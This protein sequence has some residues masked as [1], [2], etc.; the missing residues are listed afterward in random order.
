VSRSSFRVFSLAALILVVGC[1]ADPELR[2]DE[3][4]QAE[5][6]LTDRDVVHRVVI[7]GGDRESADP[8]EV[9]I[10]EGAYVQ[11]ATADWLVHEVIF[12]LDSLALEARGFLQ[13]TDQAASPPL[14]RLDSRFVLDFTDAPAG[15]YP[16]LV[17]GSSRSGR[18]VVIVEQKP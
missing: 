15:R 16:Y 3:F 5:L 14:L 2:P 4:L 18:G 11:F 13:R 9:H 8:A 17:E 7:T 10:E 6:G 12:E 1:K